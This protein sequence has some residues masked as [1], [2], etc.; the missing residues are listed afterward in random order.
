MGGLME[1]N[2]K[3]ELLFIIVIL[4]FHLFIYLFILLFCYFY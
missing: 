1:Q 2:T 3:D 4:L